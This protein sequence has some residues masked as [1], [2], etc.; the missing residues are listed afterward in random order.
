M[1]CTILY[2]IKFRKYVCLYEDIVSD[3]ADDNYIG[4]TNHTKYKRYIDENFYPVY[5]VGIPK[6]S[7]A[8]QL[9]TMFL[10]KSSKRAD[11]FSYG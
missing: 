3:G 6:K 4:Y 8:S 5:T 1:Y 11:I 2:Q 10:F 9:E 7:N